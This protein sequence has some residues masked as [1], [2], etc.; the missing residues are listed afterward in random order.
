MVGLGEVM[1]S[2]EGLQ[3]SRAVRA[4]LVSEIRNVIIGLVFI[5]TFW[6]V[7]SFVLPDGWWH[8]PINVIGFLLTGLWAWSI[9]GPLTGLTTGWFAWIMSV[10]I[11]VAT[12]VG[13]R[14]I[15]LTALE[16]I[17]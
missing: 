2:D 14:T 1:A 10:I 4:V 7:L 3:S 5:V 16:V 17:F 8:L 15:E 6:S 9:K 12:F 13:L 11:W